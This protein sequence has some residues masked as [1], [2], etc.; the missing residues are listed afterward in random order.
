MIDN[1]ALVKGTLSADAFTMVNKKILKV[2]GGDG[3]TAIVLC[4]LL[5][6]YDYMKVR[7]QVDILDSFPVSISYLKRV[8]NLSE[9]KQQRALG[10]LQAMGLATVT[11]VGMPAS[12]RVSLN[13]DRIAGILQ[14]NDIDHASERFYNGL[15]EAFNKVPYKADNFELALDN[16][17]DPFKGTLLIVANSIKERG[18]KLTWNSEVLG[19]IRSLVRNYSSPGEPFDYGRFCDLIEISWKDAKNGNDFLFHLFKNQNTVV[20]RSPQN[21]VYRHEILIKDVI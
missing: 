13:Y 11:R 19:K 18:A 10:K 14:E 2:L 1:R 4:E 3:T 16:I 20:E 17:K 6:M 21:R 7:S 15:N 12:R 8:M 9:Y 5:N